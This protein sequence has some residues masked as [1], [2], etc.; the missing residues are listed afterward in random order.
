MQCKGN[1]IHIVQEYELVT[2]FMFPHCFCIHNTTFMTYHPLL[3][4]ILDKIL[5]LIQPYPTLALVWSSTGCFMV[6]LKSIN[7]Q[8]KHAYYLA[9]SEESIQR[10]AT[11]FHIVGMNSMFQTDVP[12][13]VLVHSP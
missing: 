4:F 13:T 7:Q 12:G 10:H 9:N 8:L 3:P 2:D 6:I 11:L 1:T 5:I